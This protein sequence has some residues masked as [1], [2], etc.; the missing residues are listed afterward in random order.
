MLDIQPVVDCGRRPAKAVTG[1]AVGVSARVF[2]EGHEMLGAGVVL[3][4]PAGNCHPIVT[5]RQL[6]EGTDTYGADVSPT[7]EGLWHFRIEAWGDPIAHWRHD[8]AIKVP[9]GQDV[10]LMLAEGALLVDR[11]AR[12][13]GSAVG[14]AP[15]PAREA[16]SAVGGAPLPA[17]EAGESGL[18]EALALYKKVAKSLRS[19]KAAPVDRLGTAFTAQVTSALADFPLRELITHSAWYPLIVHR[20]RALFGSWYEFFPRSEG[21]KVDPLGRR[22]PVSGTLRTAARRLGEI[23]AMGFDVVYLPPVHPIGTTARKG[24]NNALTAGPDDPGSPWAIGSPAG[25]HDAIHPDLG[26]LDDF[27]DFV[28]KA[29]ALDL[30]VALDLALQASPDHPWVAKHP[31]WFTTRA[32]GSIAYAENP[33]KKY[34]DIYPLNFDNDPEGIY[35]EVLRVVRHWI[36]HGVTIFRVDNPHTKPLPF[37]D[38][39]LKEIAATDPHVIF[40]AEA[41]TRPAMMRALATIGFH[42]S[43]TYFTWRNTKSDLTEYLTELAGP[44][45]AYMRPNFFVNT[46]DILSSYLQHANPAAFRVRAALAALLSPSWGVYSGFELCE[47]TPLRPGSEEYLDSEK[48]QYR[49]RDWALAERTNLSISRFIAQLNAIR[50]SHPALSQLRNLRFHYPDRPEILCFSKTV[51]NTDGASA[52]DSVIVVVNLDPHQPREATIWLDRAAFDLDVSAGFTV[53]DELS[54]ESYR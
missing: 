44:A 46:P 42:Q 12:E 3:R 28:A 33:P 9:I 34:Q 21:A 5:M 50:R 2:R 30:E 43:Y 47:N 13:A 16:G 51:S 41:F 1:E 26:T 4:D 25:G 27:D 24:R 11:A 8:A 7:G 53:T 29:N 52:A 18:A 45:A 31:E 15:S 23:A 32:D 38:K 48:Y 6:T 54:G 19:G 49:P 20:E 22:R 10:D 39:L 37:W 35:S 14:D 17:R 36:S 40:L